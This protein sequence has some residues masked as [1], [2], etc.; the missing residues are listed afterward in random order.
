MPLRALLLMIL[1][2]LFMVQ[3]QETNLTLAKSVEMALENNPDLKIQKNTR[4]LAH[5]NYLQTYSGILPRLNLSA[6]GGRFTQGATTYLGDVP[7]GVDTTGN[8]IYEQRLI[9]QEG[10]ARN[11]YNMGL[12]FNWTFIDGFYSFFNIQKGILDDESAELDYLAKRN[13]IILDVKN[14]FYDAL[15]YQKLVKV[16]ELAIARSEEQLRKQRLAFQIGSATRLDT[17]KAHVSLNTDRAEYINNKNALRQAQYALNLTLGQDPGNRIRVSDN[18]LPHFDDNYSL[19]NLYAETLSS[20]PSLMSAEIATEAFEQASNAAL[21]PFMPNLTFSYSYNRNQEEF[22]NVFTFD[23]IDLDRYWSS[24]A[25][26]SLNWNLF[27]GFSDY[28]NYEKAIIAER[29]QKLAEKQLELTL[30]QS[31]EAA[32]D[33]YRSA[34]EVININEANL[35]SA[36]EDYRLATER[37]AVGSATQLEVRDAQVNLTLAEQSLVEARFN[38]LKALAQIEELTGKGYQANE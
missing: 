32:F 29:T 25:G 26:I 11:Y 6:G 3:G 20:N 9:E 37:R 7:I 19:D 13:N 17:L 23:N 36:S 5:Y 31:L 16:G 21:T 2:T 18:G 33:N 27:N 15:K 35:E 22:G 4:K 30:S 28:L 1:L 10:S 34:I 12:S 24:T 38:A 14:K 8:A